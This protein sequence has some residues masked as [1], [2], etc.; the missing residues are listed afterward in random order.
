M[1]WVAARLAGRPA[2][3]SQAGVEAHRVGDHRGVQLGQGDAGGPGQVPAVLEAG[4]FGQQLVQGR[5]AAGEPGQ[6]DPERPEPGVGAVDQLAQ[7]PGRAAVRGAQR[8]QLAGDLGS[9]ALFDVP[10][11]DQPAHGV[12]HEHHLGVGVG[13]A[14]VP[15]PLQGRLDDR[16]EP[17]GVVPA[18]QPPVIG[19]RQQVAGRDAGAGFAGHHR[20]AAR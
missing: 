13:S 7:G 12:A 1:A 14:L 3:A 19:D 17:A 16:G 8:D 2:S 5:H 4:V 15:P 10:A 11:G 9:A 20:N 6:V 18:R